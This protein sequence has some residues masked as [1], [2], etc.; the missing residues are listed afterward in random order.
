MTSILPPAAGRTVTCLPGACILCAT[1]IASRVPFP[2]SNLAAE[3]GIIT[4]D[5]FRRRDRELRHPM[6]K[7]ALP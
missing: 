2:S 1:L 7:E 3:R 6:G 4:V 5:A